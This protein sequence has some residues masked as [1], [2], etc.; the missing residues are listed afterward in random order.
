[1][2]D[3]LTRREAAELLRLHPNVV[4]GLL[5]TGALAGVRTTDTAHGHWRIPR[6]AIDDYL[7]VRSRMS[8]HAGA[9]R[10]D[11]V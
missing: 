10:A 9:L 1:M 3:I 7:G 5:Q 2:M 4:S 11:E 6:Q 8:G